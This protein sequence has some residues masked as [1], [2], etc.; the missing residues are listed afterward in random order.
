MVRHISAVGVVAA[1]RGL[2]EVGNEILPLDLDRVLR[3]RRF[4]K[5]LK[6]P[7]EVVV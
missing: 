2:E 7:V 3:S 4:H 1:A 5:H 6:L